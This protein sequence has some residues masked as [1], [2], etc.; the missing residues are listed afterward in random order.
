M[1]KF[2]LDP[3][4]PARFTAEERRRLDAMT[5]A[6]IEAAARSDRDNP[7]LTAEELRRME[8]ARLVKQVRAKTGMSQTGFAKMFRVKIGRLRDL[9]QGR[10]EADSAT[11]AYLRVIERD[12][13]YVAQALE[14][15]HH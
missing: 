13:D 10:T 7:P 1:A 14:A 15:T 4:V 3:K 2:T 6:Q 11:Q 9:E 5:P 12:P 8:S